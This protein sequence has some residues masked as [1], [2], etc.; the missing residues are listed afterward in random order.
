MRVIL[1]LSD[2]ILLIYPY[3][4]VVTKA[5]ELFQEGFGL[6]ESDREYIALF[7]AEQ[8]NVNECNLVT[9]A[10]WVWCNENIDVVRIW[11]PQ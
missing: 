2:D 8:G 6:S 7:F 10:I 1:L 3:L 9:T 4:H 11:R 5:Q